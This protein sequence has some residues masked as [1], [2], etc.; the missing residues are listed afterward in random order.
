[1]IEN[2]IDTTALSVRARSKKEYGSNSRL[3]GAL[4]ENRIC[5]AN[6]L[7][8]IFIRRLSFFLFFVSE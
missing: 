5:M 7:D 8:F 1:M 2:G 4:V 3:N 6:A